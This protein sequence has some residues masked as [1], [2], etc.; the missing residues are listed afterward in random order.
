MYNTKQLIERWPNL[1]D[2][3]RAD[4]LSAICTRGKNKGYLLE[5]CPSP[6][7][8]GRWAAW[9]AL[10]SRL[11]P[12]RTSIWSL[13]LGGAEAKRYDEIDK[14]LDASV[15]PQT[16]AFMLNSAER[17]FRFNLWANRFDREKAQ[18]IV[19]EKML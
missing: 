15:G 1:A 19:E 17:P 11:A 10:M 7:N 14:A 13:M 2:D 4:L 9:Q 6:K 12:V 18:V 3:I 5:S 16:A 8:P